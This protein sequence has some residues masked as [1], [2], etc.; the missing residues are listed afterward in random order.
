MNKNDVIEN[1]DFSMLYGYVK[2]RHN[3][4][5]DSPV[6]VF[7]ADAHC[8]PGAQT[9]IM[10]ISE[11]LIE[12]ND[13]RL[14][15]VEGSEGPLRIDSFRSARDQ[16]WVKDMVDTRFKKGEITGPERLCIESVT[17]FDLIGV[18][19][20][21]LYEKNHQAMMGTYDYRNSITSWVNNLQKGIRVLKQSQDKEAKITS[22]QISD[23]EY[24]ISLL[25]KFCQLMVTSH[26]YEAISKIRSHLEPENMLS[27]LDK[28]GITETTQDQLTRDLPKVKKLF[29]CAHDFYECAIERDKVMLENALDNMARKNQD[30]CIIVAGGFHMEAMH[31]ELK[32]RDISHL[33]ILPNALGVD[34]SKR[35]FETMEKQAQ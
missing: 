25:P 8:N 4:D 33:S 19:D 30:R 28:S 34:G 27:W 21:D 35:Y 24:A 2:Y 17:K 11:K 3:S 18:E 7:I 16:D 9:S 29:E 14:I 5:N 1:F 10:A 23:Y 15:N 6:V 20:M 12:E 31:D 26:Q 13:F 32:K 22:L